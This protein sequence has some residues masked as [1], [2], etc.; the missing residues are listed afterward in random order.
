MS[1][2]TFSIGSNDYISYASLDEANAILTIDPIRRTTWAGLDDDARMRNLIASTDRLDL[3]SW[4]GKKAGG[5]SQQNAFPRDDLTYADGTAV[6]DDDVPYAVER[7]CALL[8]GSIAL[9]PAQADQGSSG[10]RISQIRAGSV[11]IQYFRDTEAVDGK[12]LQDE[13]V[14]QLIRQ[15]LGGDGFHPPVAGGTD[16][17]SAFNERNPFGF[18]YGVG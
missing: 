4:L 9:R 2:T 8:A 13:T 1:L 10:Q 12:P 3:L 7:A 11:Q 16:A 5:A 15:W 14:H 18:R 6:P 17:K